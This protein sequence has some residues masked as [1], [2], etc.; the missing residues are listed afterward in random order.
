MQGRT[1]T[2]DEHAVAATNFPA[3]VFS[4]RQIVVRSM[5]M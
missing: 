2:S 4:F 3:S 5:S 1:G